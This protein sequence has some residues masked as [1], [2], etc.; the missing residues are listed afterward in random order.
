MMFLQE[1]NIDIWT[2]PILPI[3]NGSYTYAVAFASNRVDGYPYK[4]GVP[5]QDIG[6]EHRAGYMIEVVF[7]ELNTQA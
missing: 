2:K 4:I 7:N 1:K 5:L 6:L 3:V